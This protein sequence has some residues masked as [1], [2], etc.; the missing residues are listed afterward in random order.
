MKNE[1]YFTHKTILTPVTM[2][3]YNNNQIK[4]RTQYEFLWKYNLTLR[5]KTT[6]SK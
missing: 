2:E 6:D 5:I 4:K 1:L 3:I